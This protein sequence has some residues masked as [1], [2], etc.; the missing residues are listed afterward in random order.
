VSLESCNTVKNPDTFFRWRPCRRDSPGCLQ[1]S[2]LAYRR[3]SGPYIRALD[4]SGAGLVG[5]TLRCWIAAPGRRPVPERRRAAASGG[6]FGPL[7]PATTRLS[8]THD[9]G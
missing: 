8:K 6:K 3:M 2:E 7:S 1:P 5:S 9:S 4:P